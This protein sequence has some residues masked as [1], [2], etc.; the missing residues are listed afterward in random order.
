MNRLPNRNQLLPV[1]AVGVTILYSWAIIVT[2]RSSLFTWVL[3]LNVPEIL[4]LVAY[5]LAGAFLES[6][7]LIAALTIFGVLLPSK[8]LTEKFILRGTI[9]TITFLSSIMFYYT[10]TP[11]GEAL[12]DIYKWVLFFTVSTV[13]F[14]LAAE[15]IQTIKNTV[16]LIADRA[17][18][19][20]YIYLPISIISVI[21]V[22]IRS[23]G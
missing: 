10:Q 3:Y 11:L 1:Y 12:V 23:L 19:F 20:L 16:E 4:T 13:G 5:I 7:L 21:V 15:N 22:I 8:L 17:M 6:L 14:L 18:V 9:L 2:I